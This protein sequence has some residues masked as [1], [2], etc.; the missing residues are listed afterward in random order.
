MDLLVNYVYYLNQKKCM[1]NG[2]YLLYRNEV[3]ERE[4]K[5]LYYK[6]SEYP[7]AEFEGVSI[8]EATTS[9]VAYGITAFFV[10]G[11][12]VLDSLYTKIKSNIQ[13]DSEQYYSSYF[14]SVNAKKFRD[15]D[16]SPIKK[17]ID[18]IKFSCYINDI[19]QERKYLLDSEIFYTESITEEDNQAKIKL[20]EFVLGYITWLKN[21][22]Y[23][24]LKQYPSF[25]SPD[26]KDKIFPPYKLN[27][28]TITIEELSD[29]KFIE[30]S[31][32]FLGF[33]SRLFEIHGDFSKQ[34]LVEQAAFGSNASEESH[35]DFNCDPVILDSVY[36]KVR[37]NG[38][39]SSA[40]YDKAIIKSLLEPIKDYAIKNVQYYQYKLEKKSYSSYKY[41]C[42]YFDIN[43]LQPTYV[44]DN[45]TFVSTFSATNHDLYNYSSDIANFLIPILKKKIRFTVTSEDISENAEYLHISPARYVKIIHE[46]LFFIHLKF[47]TQALELSGKAET[48]VER[49]QNFKTIEYDFGLIDNS[50]ININQFR[51][52]ISDWNANSSIKS[53]Q[54]KKM[55]EGIYSLSEENFKFFIDNLQGKKFDTKR[56]IY[57]HINPSDATIDYLDSYPLPEEDI[58]TNQD[59]SDYCL[60]I[61]LFLKNKIFKEDIPSI[62]PRVSAPHIL[63]VKNDNDSEINIISPPEIQSEIKPI[64]SSVK[65]FKD[66]LND[67]KSL[68]DLIFDE[69]N[70]VSQ[71]VNSASQLGLDESSAV[72]PEIS[73]P[74]NPQKTKVNNPKVTILNDIW[75]GTN[76]QYNEVIK[77]LT[78]VNNNIAEIP[79]VNLSNDRLI[80]NFPAKYG[81]SQYLKGFLYTCIKNNLIKNQSARAFKEILENTFNIQIKSDDAFKSIIAN[82]PD[83]K[84]LKPFIK[85]P[86]KK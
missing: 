82:P 20:K 33:V 48:P 65:I 74:N 78:T 43:K 80:W 84:Y 56:R 34:N 19:E 28:L 36:F 64:D 38:I 4:D 25:L 60:N 73:I 63:K 66:E 9:P 69:N 24:L 49:R 81:L 14:K 70:I 61:Y 51:I 52:I 71:N 35:Y 47:K 17:L 29:L 75:S 57:F 86:T 23:A 2:E 15:N 68:D 54:F 10:G 8:I 22:A 53:E 31:K 5:S 55:L 16:R 72:K 7:H 39:L 79:L 40:N 18:E 67:A 26:L 37:V 46:L 58:N 12:P 21:K 45:T 13:F 3:Y 59:F 32:E 42:I 85:F 76:D 44:R 27:E 30:V 50:L 62:Q 41:V 11:V 6:Y 1:Q 77:I 83:E